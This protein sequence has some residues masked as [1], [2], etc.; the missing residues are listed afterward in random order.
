MPAL[1]RRNESSR[2][3]RDLRRT[4]VEQRVLEATERLLEA[5]GS[6]IDLKVEAIAAEAG[7]SRSGFY[8][9]FDDKQALLVRLLES[10]STP[11]LARVAADR[12]E[13]ASGP[14]ELRGSLA[15]AVAYADAHRGVVRAVLEAAT[16]D[17]EIAAAW[18]EL[19]D[20]FVAAAA[21]RT[22]EQQADGAALDLPA[23]Q[24]AVTLVAMV[25]ETLRRLTDGSL[26]LTPDEAVDAMTLVWVRTVYGDV[27]PP[28]ADAA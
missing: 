20:R 1:S 9:Y 17:P 10:L 11:L 24:V 7:L 26:S 3:R 25:T 8:D 6:Y 16:Y 5:G 23:E 21:A 27:V 15:R 13:V 2:A 14:E 18:R 4:Q 12:A 28:R 22:R 19:T